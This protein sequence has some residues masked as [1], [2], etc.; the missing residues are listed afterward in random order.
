[1]SNIA[2]VRHVF[3]NLSWSD[4][5]LPINIIIAIIIG[6]V[7]SKYSESARNAFQGEKV[8]NVPIPLAIGMVIMMVPPLCKVQWENMI[9]LVK[10]K[11]FRE[12]ML[13][14]LI[15]GW[16]LCPFLMF[17]LAW[18]SLFDQAE[19]RIG[20]ILTGCA[21]CIAMV[22]VWNEVAGGDTDLC[23]VLVIINSVLQIILYAPY[24]I[25]FCDIMGG[26]GLYQG[27]TISTTYQTVAQTVGFFLG[28]PMAGGFL[29]RSI[30]MLTIGVDKFEKKI[31]PFIGP[32]GMIG[33]L[34]TIIVIFIEKG[35]DF[36]QE[37]GTA[38]RC[39]VPLISYFIISWSVAFFG[40]RFW[41]SRRQLKLGNYDRLTTCG[42]EKN[43][44][45][46]E[47]RKRSKG[48]C[49]A[50]YSQVITQS[51]VA[52]SNNFELSLTVAIALYGTD[53]RQAIAA[54][55]GPLIEIPVLLILCFVSRFFQEKLLWKD[56]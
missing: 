22:L 14:S 30:G 35:D 21:R 45:Q 25:L 9:V 6:L 49:S 39:F 50:S 23:A 41:D 2:L 31:M 43:M 51:L 55:F 4:K 54:T 24:K 10:K 42:C 33:L 46:Y 32:F 8:L 47:S 5:L 56:V 48:W 3:N 13:I 29:I 36:L 52:S 11:N 40:L 17:G 19:Y 12:Q 34:Y 37:I 15:I 27:V 20:V 38:F 18:L 7:I 44:E 53:S 26:S 1:M 16:V 28:I